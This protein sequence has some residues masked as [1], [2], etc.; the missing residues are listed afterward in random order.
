MYLHL[1]QDVLVR[2]KDV[3][4]ILDLET[5]TTISRITKDFL[6]TMETE[7]FVK[8]VSPGALPKSFVICSNDK[9]SMVYITNISAKALLGRVS[10]DTGV[11]LK[12]KES[13]ANG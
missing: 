8:D 9:Q 13:E 6:K 1:G 2:E 4:A 11:K 12:F 10:G 7:G 3:I 5:T